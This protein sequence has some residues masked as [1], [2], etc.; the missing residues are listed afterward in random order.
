MAEIAVVSSRKARLQQ[1]ADEGNRGAVLA[2]KTVEEPAEFLSTVQVWITLIGI[3][4]GAFGGATLSAP[5]AQ[6]IAAIPALAPYAGALA[7]AIVVVTIT[8]FSL[9]IGELVPKRVGLSSPESIAVRVVG[10]MRVLARI[11]RPI[12]WLLTVTSNLIVRVLHLHAQAGPPVTQAE[13]EVMLEQGAQAGVLSETESEVAQSV[14]RLADRRVGALMTPRMDI[15]WLDAA[16]TLEETRDIVAKYGHSRYPVCDG[17]LD[18]VLGIVD[19][20]QLLAATITGQPMD[21]GA[22]MRRPLFVPETVAAVQLLD[23]FYSS[24]QHMAI[25]VDEYGGTQGLVTVHDLL[26]AVVGDVTEA[27]QA[28]DARAVR[29]EDGTW[30]LDGGLP[31]EDFRELFDLEALPGETENTFETL[32]GFVM[33]QLGHIPSVADA[34][35]WSD[36]RFEV[37][38]MDGKRVDKVLVAPLEGA[39]TTGE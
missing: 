4:A 32:G 29:R 3:L 15:A 34:F 23:S 28:A 19:A 2:L 1:R 10:P 17:N 21:V 6:K 8:F 30:L 36:Y 16:G 7:Y 37:M 9:V 31:V 12:V 39:E 18:N 24:G 13:I 27:A 22:L 38:D 5:L 14:F 26:E 33:A 11:I 20:Q 35:E 25:V